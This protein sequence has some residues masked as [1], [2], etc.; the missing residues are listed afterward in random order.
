MKR[1]S[2]S[3][4]EVTYFCFDRLMMFNSTRDPWC[5]WKSQRPFVEVLICLEYWHHPFITCSNSFESTL[6]NYYLFHKQQ[7]DKDLHL[8]HLL[9]NSHHNFFFHVIQKTPQKH[10]GQFDLHY[11]HAWCKLVLTHPKLHDQIV[12]KK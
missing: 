1:A 2:M 12:I 9:Y 10:H 5:F 4:N 6:R 3:M 11:S 8:H 7:M